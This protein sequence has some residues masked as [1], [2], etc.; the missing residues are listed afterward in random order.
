MT[1][2]VV[3]PARRATCCAGLL[4]VLLWA[5]AVGAQLVPYNPPKNNATT[6]YSITQCYMMG[7]GAPM[8]QGEW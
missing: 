3:A 5:V 6:C 8:S 7:L 1:M 4:V 2:R